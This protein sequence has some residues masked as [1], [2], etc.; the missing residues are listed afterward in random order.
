MTWYSVPDNDLS[1]YYF[2]LLH[3]FI[4]FLDPQ[5][6]TDG[7]VFLEE[8]DRTK[9]SKLVAVNAH[10]ENI[11]SGLVLIQEP[12]VVNAVEILNENIF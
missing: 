4:L 6:A 3:S 8:A 12:Y 2:D 9:L 5:N 7:F 10:I 1:G 11:S